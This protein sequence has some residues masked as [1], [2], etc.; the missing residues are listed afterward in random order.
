M[1]LGDDEAAANDRVDETL[2]LVGLPV[3]MAERKPHEVSGGQRQRFA[4]C[5]ALIV[6]PRILVCDEVVSALD[7][8]VQGTVLN[9]LRSYCAAHDAGLVSVSHGLP[10]TAFIADDLIV[11]RYGEVVESRA[12]GVGPVQQLPPLHREPRR[13]LSRRRSAEV[14]SAPASSIPAVPAPEEVVAS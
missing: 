7:V 6:S 4:I 12:D 8:S 13:G 9:F 5:R 11:M 10:A 2:E 1:L 3:G 14:G